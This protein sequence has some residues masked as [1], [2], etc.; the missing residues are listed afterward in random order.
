[1]KRNITLKVAKFFGEVNV[2]NLPPG[3]AG[4]LPLLLLEDYWLAGRRHHAHF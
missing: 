3:A 2:P 4:R 1:M